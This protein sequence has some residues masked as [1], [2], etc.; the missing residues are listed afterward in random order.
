MGS[1]HELLLAIGRSDEGADKLL[2]WYNR[3]LHGDEPVPADWGRAVMVLLPKCPTPE[4]PKQ[5][6]PICLGSAAN[7]VYARML[8]AR[9]RPAFQYSGPFQNLG[10]G[11]Q[12]VDHVWIISRLMALDREWK[13]GLWYLKLD[14]SKA[15]DSLHRGKFLRRLSEKLGNCEELRSWWNLFRHTEAGLSTAWGE[16]SFPLL[17]GVRQGSVESPQ[18]FASAMDW[19]LADVVA[20]HRW[21][22][23]KDVLAGL[24]FAETAFMDDCILWDGS[25][26]SLPV[27]AGQELAEWGLWVNPE[28]SQ[29][30]HSPFSTEYGSLRVGDQDVAPDDRLDVMGIPFAS[31]V[32]P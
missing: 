29:V 8:L 18:A 6:R 26:L 13:C 28:K 1:R 12:T 7:K 30:Y 31:G 25:K 5:L 14:I 2:A 21:D 4:H 20:K 22:P 24:Q 19:I 9:S 32:T 11:R 23:G 15:F 3:L 17:S 10:H 27:R 16:S